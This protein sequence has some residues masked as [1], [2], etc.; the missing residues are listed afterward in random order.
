[1]TFSLVL[2]TQKYEQ[3]YREYIVE[4]GDEERYPFQLDLDHHDFNALLKRLDEFENGI[5][6]P[7]GY[8][9]SSTFW[10]VD[11]DVLV[12]VSSLRHHLN[13]KIKECGGHIGLG[14]RPSYR[15]R[16]L[17][18]ELLALTIIEA[19]QRGI[20][21]IHIHCHKDNEASGR[22]IVRNGGVLHSEI[23]IGDPAVTVQRYLIS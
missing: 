9:Q 22:M 18:T 3:S 6:I 15:G 11:G 8:V 12:G 2:P 19:R 7:K 10:L 21:E 16:G 5:D 13:E 20:G 23:E 1:M 17:G 4:L 14:V